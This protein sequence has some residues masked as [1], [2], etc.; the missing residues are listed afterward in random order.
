MP[1][2]GGCFTSRRCAS[3][4]DSAGQVSCNLALAAAVSPVPGAS[5]SRCRAPQG[6]VTLSFF[7]QL[8]TVLA[9]VPRL[10]AGLTQRLGDS[11]TASPTQCG[12]CLR[13]CFRVVA[14]AFTA[15]SAPLRCGAHPGFHLSPLQRLGQPADLGGQET[16]GGRGMPLATARLSPWGWWLPRRALHNGA[17]PHL[18]LRRIITPDMVSFFHN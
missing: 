7:A 14:A 4:Q 8:L 12:T 10:T 9:P 1:D 17:E 6:F 18:A 13:R 16:G 2:G 3:W 15:L 11:R 5:P